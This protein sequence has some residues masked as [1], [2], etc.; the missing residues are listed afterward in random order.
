MAGPSDPKDRPYFWA[1]TMLARAGKPERARQLLARY[2]AEDPTGAAA[3][4]NQRQIVVVDGEIALAEGKAAEAVQQFRAGDLRE[5]GA[6]IQCDACTHFNLARAFDA[7]GQPDSAVSYFERYL[8][9][10]APRRQ[11][12]ISLAAVE[13][14]LGELYDSRN[15]RQKAITH[16]AAFVDQ[17]K[18]ADAE[19]Q[20]VVATVKRRLNELRGQEGE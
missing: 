18:D 3:A 15:E 14:R 8:A 4:P 9:I 1:A 2:R 10:P 12:W 20:P 17:W 6:P 19:L 7:A 16:Y 13:K 5:D 11:D